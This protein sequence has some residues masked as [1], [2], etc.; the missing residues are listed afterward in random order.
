MLLWDDSPVEGSACVYI[1]R[2]TIRNPSFFANLDAFHNFFSRSCKRSALLCE[3]DRAVRVS[4]GS[5]VRWN[6]KSHAVHA[7]HEGRG[8][9]CIAFDKKMTEPGWDKET[10]AQSASLKQNLEDFDFTFL[11]E[12]SFSPFSAS[13]NHSSR[14]CKVRRWT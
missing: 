8:S 14:F 5:A 1:T 2:V 7:I 12:V 13:Q 10:I 3:V 4:G 6:F 11:L 9:L